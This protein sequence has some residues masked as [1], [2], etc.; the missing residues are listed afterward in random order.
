MAF[1]R[2]QI[3]L[4]LRD[5]ARR[6]GFTQ[7]VVGSSGGIDSAITLALAAEAFGP[8][9]VT[10]ITM[11]SAFSSDRLGGRLANRCATGWACGCTGIRSP[12][13]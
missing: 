2:Q 8:E 9:R 3:V 1:Y 7:A 4:G 10:A 12:I 6:C 11:P 13:W 5:Y